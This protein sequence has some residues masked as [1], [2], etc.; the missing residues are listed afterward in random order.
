MTSS[1]CTLETVRSTHAFEIVGYSLHKRIGKGNYICSATFFIGGYKWDIHYYLGRYNK[2]DG[3]E[4]IYVF[5]EL[6]SKGCGV[7]FLLDLRLAE[8]ASGQSLSVVS[9]ETPTIFKAGTTWCYSRFRKRSVL[10]ASPYL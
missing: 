5:I 1:R 8:E 4:Y 3:E 6:M 10:E 9:Q 7:E 2:E